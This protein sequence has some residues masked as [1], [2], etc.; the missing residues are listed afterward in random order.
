MVSVV[1]HYFCSSIGRKQLIGITG[2]ALCGFLIAHLTGNFL[3][4]L[5]PAAF[6][7]YGHKL[8]S[9][10][11][12]YLA[13]AGL[14][15]IFL[16]HLGLA[17]KVTLENK[18]A[19]KHGYAKKVRTGRGATIMSETMPYTGLV[20][21]A[22]IISHLLH[23]KFG[24]HYETVVDGVAMRDLYKVVM[25]FFVSPIGTAWYV[26]A[27]ICATFHTSHGFSSAFQ[28]LGLNHPKYYPSIKKLGYLYAL[29]V[30]GGFTL[31]AV[32]AHLKGV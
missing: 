31:L 25:E 27:M 18:A 11:L 6:N 17:F 3:L 32:W 12:I 7:L 8:T 21:L 4:L 15:V 2:L 22:F 13:E 29:F 9:N 20:L 24:N 1:N 19:R 26:F 5:G 28:S 23:F 10:P 14:M 30:G 16:L